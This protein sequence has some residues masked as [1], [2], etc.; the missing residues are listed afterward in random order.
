MKTKHID[1][2]QTQTV[3]EHFKLIQEDKSVIDP[4][5]A[6]VTPND[7]PAWYNEKL[8]K[9]GQN[10]Y[11]RNLMSVIAATTV[12][13]VLVF[14]VDTILKILVYTKRSSSVSTAF[15]RYIETV[16]HVH[17]LYTCDVNDTD[18][19]WYKS[20]NTIRWYHKMGTR[21]TKEA[22]VGEISQRDMVLTQYAFVAFIY[23]APKLFGVCN[24]L[25]EDEGFNHF[26]RI[27]GYMLGI[28]DRL[29]LCRK[30]ARETTEL[31]RKIKQVYADYL[32]KPPSEFYE[33][34][35]YAL[36]AMWYID[37]T[38]DKDA[39]MTHTYKL[40]GLSYK[41]IGWYSW[42]ITKYREFMFYLCLVPYVRVL[43]KAYGNF[44]VWFVLWNAANFP[45]LAWINLGK[46]NI[47][48][49]MYPNKH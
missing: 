18:S 37:I 39:F 8:Y 44:I 6:D 17:N 19:K 30:N 28:P 23:T 41:E 24:T 47:R 46:D 35:T 2:V 13:L 20:M 34:T 38:V 42:I 16:L 11:K 33:I 9:E 36:D 48:L 5:A 21:K 49:N 29:N 31:C 25:E 1:D 32:K 7:L 14:T 27:N 40:H 26:W 15:K 22:G 4:E 45:L 3:D 10:F 43:A 12:G